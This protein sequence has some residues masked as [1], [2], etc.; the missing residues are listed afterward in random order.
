MEHSKLDGLMTMEE[1]EMYSDTDI[2]ELDTSDL[3]SPWW[4]TALKVGLSLLPAAAGTV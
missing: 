4:S 3:T 1:I 2:G